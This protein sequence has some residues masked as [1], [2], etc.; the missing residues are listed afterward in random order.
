VDHSQD[1][2][3]AIDKREAAISRVIGAKLM[4][5]RE[6]CGLLIEDAAKLLGIGKSE[7]FRI[8][9][10]RD[11][12]TIPNWLIRKAA[13][14]YDIGIDFLYGL[15]ADD[16]E[17]NEPKL[18]LER[19]TFSEMFQVT[20]DQVAKTEN[21]QRKLDNK[22]TALA[23]TVAALP[24]AVKAVDD[25]FMEDFWQR[26]P[27]FDEML[28]GATFIKHLDA[29]LKIAAECNAEMVRFKA[30]HRDAIKVFNP[31]YVH[32]T[33]EKRLQHLKNNQ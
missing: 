29:A 15:Q 14:V 13:I 32:S 27:G 8:E 31:E 21:E 7:L 3:T 28:G 25:S 6:L 17:A 26:N 23:N 2:G 10:S 5:A 24:V 16:W 22:I 30:I 11:L 19:D 33:P 1:S 20:L 12:T 9:R 4:E 18:R